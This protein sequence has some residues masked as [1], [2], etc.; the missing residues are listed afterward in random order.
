MTIDD[1]WAKTSP[2]GAGWHCLRAHMLD[3]A[4][5]ALRM[6]ERSPEGAVWERWSGGLSREEMKSMLALLAGAHDV[7]KANPYFQTKN[8]WQRERLVS[9]GYSLEVGKEPENARHGYATG[10][11]LEE[12]LKES[13]GFSQKSSNAIS[14]V[15]GGHHGKYFH[16]AKASTLGLT[17]EPWCSSGRE[18]LLDLQRGVGTTRIDESIVSNPFLAWLS[19]FVTVADWIGSSEGMVIF[20]EAVDSVESYFLEA[21]SRADLVLDEIGWSSP[22]A[23]EPRGLAELLPEGSEPRPLQKTAAEIA[24]DGASFVIIEAPTGEG[25]TEAAFALAETAR[26]HGKGLFFALPTMATANGLFDRV[27]HYLGEDSRL[28]LLHSKAW[29]REVSTVSTDGDSVTAPEAQDWFG[30]AKRGLLF[31]YGVGTI[32]QGLMGVLKTR[33]FFVRLFALAGKT[34]VVDEVHAYDVYM[35]ELLSNLLR[36]LKVMGCRVVLMS[37]T[38]PRNRRDALVEA[39]SGS[40]VAGGYPGL[41]VVDDTGKS[42]WHGIAVATRKPLHLRAERV[43]EIWRAGAELCVDLVWDGGCT[44]FILNTVGDAQK[45]VKFLSET[46]PEMNVDL[47][48]ARF[49][50]DDRDKI[51]SRVLRTFG[52]V[53]GSGEGRVL[54][55][56]QVVEQSLDLD[57][58]HMVSALAPVDL[59]IQRAGRLHRHTRDSFGRLKDGDDERAEAVLHVLAKGDSEG[60]LRLE[61]QVYEPMILR[62]TWEAIQG[63]WTICEASEVADLVEDVYDES[64][65]DEIKSQSDEQ[66]LKELKKYERGQEISH[67]RAEDRMIYDPLHE[68]WIYLNRIDQDENDERPGSMFAARTRLEERPSLTL[69]LA[70]VEEARGMSARDLAGREISVSPPPELFENL[71]AFPRLD[72]VTG[73][74]RDFWKILVGV[75]EIGMKVG[76]YRILYEEPVDG[77]VRRGLVW[78]RENE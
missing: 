22:G 62:R 63:G 25:K 1:L 59:L 52:K 51:E 41:S 2:D 10:V 37:A 53:R 67:D 48:H 24:A 58:D 66:R 61:G 47:F 65:R 20:V 29:L 19:G 39:W 16:E 14:K 76:S 56:T 6:V 43:D 28:R 27:A 46:Y 45:A 60:E 70:S 40:P 74:R 57:F 11:F 35:G 73:W 15:V 50:A 49:S 9:L 71:K 75:D 8:K 31:P 5:V 23:G 26:I 55:A 42:S 21:L 34:V 54:V 13:H 4:A 3:V 36:W 64:R 78:E 69:V 12:W 32:D 7:G 30:G 33:H 38:L 17:V 44:A 77:A 18:L 68:K 72:S